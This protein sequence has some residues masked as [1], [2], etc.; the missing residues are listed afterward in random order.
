MVVPTIGYGGTD[1]G[2]WWYQEA[3]SALACTARSLG[4]EERGEEEEREGG[5]R[6]DGERGEGGGE[7]E[8]EEGEGERE[9]E[10][11]KRTGGREGEGGG[12]QLGRVVTE[13]NEGV[14]AFAICLRACY[15]MPGTEMAYGAVCLRY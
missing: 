1:D 9:G 15:A 11:E 8:R 3:D 2:L 10:R 12:A 13:C 7:R 5:E 6:E 14:G 4:L